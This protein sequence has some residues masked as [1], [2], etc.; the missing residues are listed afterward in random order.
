MKV[1]RYNN[2]MKR[3]DIDIIVG[4]IFFLVLLIFNKFELR[5]N[6]VDKL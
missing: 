1:N 3:G 5:L 4:Y 6:I 2:N